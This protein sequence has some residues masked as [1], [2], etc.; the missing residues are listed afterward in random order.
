MMPAAALAVIEAAVENAQRRG[1]DSPQDMA[2]HVV[3][4]LVAHGWTIAVADQDNRPAAA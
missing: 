1:L 4:E 2:E 3:G